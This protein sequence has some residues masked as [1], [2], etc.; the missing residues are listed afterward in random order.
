M[1]VISDLNWPSKSN[2]VVAKRQKLSLQQKR[3]VARGQ[4]KK[5]QSALKQPVIDESHLGAAQKGIVI[6]RYGEQADI[7]DDKQNIYRLYLRQNLGSCVSGDRVV[8]RLD[9]QQQG[10][11]EAIEERTSE[12]KRPTP[13]AGVKT[14]V[15]NVD[16][17][18]V[19][20]A[21]LPD[22]SSLILDRYLVA[23]SLADIPASI[24]LN[25]TDLLTEEQASFFEQ[26]MSIYR[27]IGY[28]VY[29]T[30][31]KDSATLQTLLAAMEGQENIL[32]GQS[33]VGKSSLINQLVPHATIETGEVSQNSKLGTHTTTASRLY[34]LPK[35]GC[36]I[37]S[38]GV[39]E[40]A[41]WHIEAEDLIKGFIDL[42]AFQSQCKFRNCQ[43]Q[44]EKG[45][46]IT[47]AAQKQLISEQ[48]LT[49]FQKILTQLKSQNG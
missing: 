7:A 15:A 41:L 23:C 43:H 28:Q 40:F 48:R 33:G 25:K 4:H 39:R 21:P 29:N 2:I 26:Q 20:V 24:V 9:D 49:N 38:P 34:F 11:I 36:I 47:D 12:L 13:H 14:I 37:D 35:E 45:C 32:V 17:I 16:H 6:S 46:A 8:F 42:R 31:K 5:L 19:V 1:W 3:R 18:F 30:N 22:Y 44:N 27:S 10:V